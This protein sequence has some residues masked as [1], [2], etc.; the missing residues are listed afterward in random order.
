LAAPERSRS[1]SSRPKDTAS[2]VTTATAVTSAATARSPSRSRS[3]HKHHDDHSTP[4]AK[5]RC[6]RCIEKRQRKLSEANIEA[7]PKL[8]VTKLVKVEERPERIVEERPK[9]RPKER[10]R[11]RPKAPPHVL[12]VRATEPTRSS[13]KKPKPVLGFDIPKKIEKV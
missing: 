6:R 1:R 11:E 3:H 7:V 8:D 5:A 9:E 10:P 12:E 4:E 2:R 13:S